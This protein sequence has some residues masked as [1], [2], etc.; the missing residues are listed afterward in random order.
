MK[1]A[2]LLV[3]FLWILCGCMGTR[4]GNPMHRNE[5]A[6]VVSS[7]TTAHATTWF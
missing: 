2:L 3:P 1:K 4:H 7:T 6:A 5:G